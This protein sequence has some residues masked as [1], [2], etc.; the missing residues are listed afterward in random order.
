MAAAHRFIVKLHDAGTTF[1]IVA[2]A[3][4]VLSV[5]KTSEEVVTREL[6]TVTVVQAAAIFTV[7]LVLLIVWFPVVQAAVFVAFTVIFQS[8]P[9]LNT[10]AAVTEP[11]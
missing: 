6:V 4:L 9:I 5:A 7:P 10:S 11:V 3:S 2:V 1:L 8:F